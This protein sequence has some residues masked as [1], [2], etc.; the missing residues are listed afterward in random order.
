MNYTSRWIPTGERLPETPGLYLA[1]VRRLVIDPKFGGECYL[2][3]HE[4]ALFDGRDFDGG[5]SDTVTGY[6]ER[7]LAWMPLPDLYKEEDT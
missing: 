4:I 5:D 7:V 1:T 2:D 3:D 6:F